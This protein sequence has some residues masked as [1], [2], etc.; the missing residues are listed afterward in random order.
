MYIFFF[1]KN[2]FFWHEPFCQMIRPL[3]YVFFTCLAPLFGDPL[4]DRLRDQ[5]NQNDFSKNFF[6]ANLLLDLPSNNFSRLLIMLMLEEENTCKT[7]NTIT[8]RKHDFS[9][10]LRRIHCVYI[11]GIKI[12]L[13][14]LNNM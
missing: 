2:E 7:T 13:T 12:N 6:F 9:T 10:L 5:A 11:F 4:G 8:E 14:Y 3:L 1:T